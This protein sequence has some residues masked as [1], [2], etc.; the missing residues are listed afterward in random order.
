MAVIC[1]QYVQKN[2]FIISLFIH[3]S[4]ILQII[5]ELNFHFARVKVE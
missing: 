5:M 2:Y 1:Y 3:F 4:D